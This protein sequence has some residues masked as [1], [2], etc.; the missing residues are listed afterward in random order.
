M[1]KYI[2]PILAIIPFVLLIASLEIKVFLFFIGTMVVV[3]LW[4][5]GMKELL[6]R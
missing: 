1:K 6:S 5:W 4:A 3:F 2:L